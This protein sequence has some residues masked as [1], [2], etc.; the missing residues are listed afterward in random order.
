MQGRGKDRLEMMAAVYDQR[1]ASRARATPKA[2][3]PK[4][5][6]MHYTQVVKTPHRPKKKHSF[7]PVNRQPSPLSQFK[8][9]T[10]LP[11][12]KTAHRT[13]RLTPRDLNSTS[14]HRRTQSQPDHKQR[15]LMYAVKSLKGHLPG[16][17]KANQD[18]S[19]SYPCVG[20]HPQLHAFGVCDGH[21]QFGLE[22][23]KFVAQTLP[24]VLEKDPE[25][26]TDPEKS[27]TASVIAVDY[28]LNQSGIDINFSGTTM[29]MALIH[30]QTVLCG[31]VGDSRAFI[32]HFTGSKWV[33]IPLS[34]DH[35]PSETDEASRIYDWNGRIEPYYDKEHRPLGPLRVWLADED[36]PGL[37]MTRSIGDHIA[38]MAGVSSQAEVKRHDLDEM[39][40]ILVLGSDGLFE[41][42]SN[43][44]L[45]ALAVPFLDTNNPRGATE[46]LVQAAE[47]RWRK[48]TSYLGR[49]SQRR[50]HVYSCLP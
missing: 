1:R 15:S 7:S 50:H 49:R 11:L 19:F 38:A 43:E 32:G 45:L 13:Q 12:L 20:G 14:I 46:K 33:P 22:I 36:I 47:A 39:D 16:T 24:L 5:V 23:S 28:H 29:V 21:G 37:A 10:H 31:N 41:F 42:L 9:T 3:T 2:R 27:I 26:M 30:R 8:P 17:T 35:K 4:A 40:K 34:R 48:V 6:G 18:S 25:L 44:E